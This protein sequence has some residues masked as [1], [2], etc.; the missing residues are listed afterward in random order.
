M[1]AYAPF[2]I[3]YADFPSYISAAEYNN[4]PT[5]VDT[6]NLLPNG[7][8]E[9][10]A[11]ALVETIARA[12]SVIDG[13]L[14]GAYGTLNATVNTE[15]A[16]IWSNR[17]NSF[18]V[19]PKYWP[20]LE[21][22]SFTFGPTPQTSASVTPSGNIWIEPSGF[23]VNFGGEVGLGLGSLA[24]VV[25]CFPYFCQ[26]TYVNGWPNTSLSASVAPSAASVNLTS[27]TG[28]YPGTELT[29][30]DLPNDEAI[31]V[32]STYVPGTSP[33]P[34]TGT[35]QYAHAAGTQVSNI[36]K[37]VKQAAISLTTYL[38][39]TRGSGALVIESLNGNVSQDTETVQGAASD[40]ALAKE[41]LAPLRTPY[42]GY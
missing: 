38:I 33:V 7:S 8:T 12:S 4:A 10:Q 36:P 2:N 11:A 17:E 5:A 21:V 34:L 23:V 26:W 3:S 32:A 29:I 24:G 9:T 20:V 31:T 40:L 37:R 30:F 16:R 22:Q 14:F 19:H 39:K 25:S 18:T 6:S 42:V 27:L 13:Y 28:I 1:S 15:N 41:L 35:I